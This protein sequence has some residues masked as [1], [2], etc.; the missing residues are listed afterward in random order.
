MARTYFRLAAFFV[1]LAALLNPPFMIADE[2]NH[3]FRAV[4]IS[5]GGLIGERL[6]HGE[7]G[8]MLAEPVVNFGYGFDALRFDPAARATLQHLRFSFQ[9]RWRDEVV[10]ANF[11]NT[12][13]YPPQFYL[14]AALTLT[15]TRQLHLRVLQAFYIARLASGLI[16]VALSAFA[17]RICAPSA[18]PWLLFCLSLPEVTG[19]YGSLSQDGPFIMCAALAGALLTREQRQRELSGATAL[20]AVFVSAK[21]PYWPLLALP[22]ILAARPRRRFAALLVLLGL[23]TVLAWCVF[24]LR[25]LVTPVRHG[26]VSPSRQLHYLFLHPGLIPRLFAATFIK[27]GPSLMAGAVGTVGWIEATLPR[28]VYALVLGTGLLA[29]SLYVA[30]LPRRW[31]WRLALLGLAVGAAGAG[32]ALSTYLTWDEVGQTNIEGLLG[33]Y[34]IPLLLCLT[35]A[36]S[37][38]GPGWNRRFALPWLSRWLLYGLMPLANLFYLRGVFLRFWW[39]S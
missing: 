5:Q 18:R 24:G 1:I 11:P 17:L 7:A 27:G 14:P 9:K 20:L 2:T 10:A 12:V 26:D 6:P 4:Q 29:A 33:R 36:A 32:V 34:F 31:E 25:P 22:L 23:A 13:I 3:F 35:P 38:A 15:F 16:C 8:G 21:P 39:P 30:S 28:W 19:L 37:W